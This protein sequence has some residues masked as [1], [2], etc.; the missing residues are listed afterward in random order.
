MVNLTDKIRVV[1]WT[2]YVREYRN[3]KAMT[4]EVQIPELVF[5]NR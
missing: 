5:V 4:G 3:L 2:Q 1:P